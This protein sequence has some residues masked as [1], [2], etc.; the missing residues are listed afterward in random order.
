MSQKLPYGTKTLYTKYELEL[1]GVRIRAKSLKFWK[2]HR[3]P[4]IKFSIFLYFGSKSFAWM[5]GVQ[6]W[7]QTLNQMTFDPIV[8]KKKTVENAQ[9][10][11]K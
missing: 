4:N 1:S 9:K 10:L 6:I 3:G 8:T 5:R 2:W 7:S 11:A